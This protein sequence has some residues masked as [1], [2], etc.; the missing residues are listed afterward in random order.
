MYI[1][2]IAQIRNPP[3]AYIMT[4]F[5]PVHRNV[6]TIGHQKVCN[7]FSS[8][9]RNEKIFLQFSSICL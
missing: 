4:D 5:V 6:H 9:A 3:Y 1:H 8:M 7:N 2:S